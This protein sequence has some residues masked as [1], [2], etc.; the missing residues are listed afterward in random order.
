MKFVQR[1]GTGKTIHTTRVGCSLT[2]LEEGWVVR[3]GVLIGVVA[4]TLQVEL[5]PENREVQED[6][7]PVVVV[8]VVLNLL[9]EAKLLDDW[10][11]HGH[12]CNTK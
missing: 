10:S 9:P 8:G 1:G 7:W 5:V 2:S 6:T 3:S 11:M 4:S 12:A